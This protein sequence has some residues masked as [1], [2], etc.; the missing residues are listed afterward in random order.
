MATA[1]SSALEAVNISNNTALEANEAAWSPD[2]SKI[3]FSATGR[4]QNGG[5]NFDAQD[6]GVGSILLQAGLMIGV[7][8]FMAWRWQLPFG[9][10]TLILAG[11]TFM[12]TLLNDFYILTI[13]ALLAG[14][15]AD[16]FLWA[17]FPAAASIGRS[18]LEHSCLGRGDFPVR[19]ARPVDELSDIGGGCGAGDGSLTASSSSPQ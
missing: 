11:S 6:F 18:R 3:M 5:N 9:A 16:D 14:L 12:L 10:M 19:D 13:S 1:T 2:G 15:I 7:V 17:V 8:L 4:T